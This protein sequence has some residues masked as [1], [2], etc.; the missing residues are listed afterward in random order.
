[1]APYVS[2]LLAVAGGAVAVFEFSENKMIR[3]FRARCTECPE[4]TESTWSKFD[5]SIDWNLARREE[6]TNKK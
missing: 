1:M 3:K 2:I 6:K 5:A 4:Q